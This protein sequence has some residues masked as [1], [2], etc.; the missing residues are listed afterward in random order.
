MLKSVAVILLRVGAAAGLLLWQ[1][2]QVR[3]IALTIV[4]ACLSAAVELNALLAKLTVDTM[5]RLLDEAA[6]H[7]DEINR[8]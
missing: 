4:L 2:T 5:R 8:R 3:S 6:E 1:H 7:L